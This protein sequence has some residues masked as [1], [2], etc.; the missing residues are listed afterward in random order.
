MCMSSCS[1]C[2]WMMLMSDI[3]SL[4]TSLVKI[5]VEFLTYGEINGIMNRGL[6]FDRMQSFLHGTL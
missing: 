3:K 5:F 2:R 6:P 1:I 4:F